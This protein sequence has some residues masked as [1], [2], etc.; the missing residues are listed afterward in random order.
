VKN[1]N[2]S[3]QIAIHSQRTSWVIATETPIDF[4]LQS[5]DENRDPPTTNDE[6]E[7]NMET[8]RSQFRRSMI[9]EE[10]DKQPSQKNPEKTKICVR[11][12]IFGFG[13]R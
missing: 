8:T 13:K 3:K 10:N 1:K 11:K 4:S 6:S 7:K 2:S 9:D 5:Q 12:Q